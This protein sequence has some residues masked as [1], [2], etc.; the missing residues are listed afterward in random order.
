MLSLWPIVFIG[1]ISYSLY[2]WHWPLTVFQRTDALLSLNSSATAK[3][4]L[5]VMSVGIAYLSWK[6]I[7]LP[8]RALARKTSKIA[9]FTSASTAMASAFALCGLVL[10]AG[11]APSRF[12]QRVVA[13]GS[14]LAYD[15]RPRSAPV[16]ASC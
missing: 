6:L 15:L 2:L 13:I 4:M 14:Y 12:P 7:E 1:L 9:V 3:L 16:V 5:I 10:V 11:G 8:F